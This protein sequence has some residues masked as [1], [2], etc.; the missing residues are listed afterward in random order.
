MVP[1]ES[2][3]HF[4]LRRNVDRQEQFAA[5]GNPDRTKGRDTM[6]MRY[7]ACPLAAVI[8][9]AAAGPSR[10]DL[11]KAQDDRA[12]VAGTTTSVLVDVLANDGELG[13]GLRILK[14]FKPAHGSVSVE[15]GRVRYTPTRGFTGSDSFRYMAQAEKSQPGQATVNV[16]VGPGGVA[17]QLR[18]QV[19][20][21]PIPG[22]VVT[23]S[24]GGFDFKTVA[25]ANGNYVLDIAALQGDAFVTLTA[26]GESSSGVPITFYSLVGEIVRLNAASGSDG[27]LTRDEFNQLNVTN[28]STAQYSLL[29]SAN[30]GTPPDSDQELLPL[31]QNIDLDKMLELA[32]IIKLVV[33]GGVA[34]PAGSTDLLDLIS[35]PAAVADFKADLAPGQ[36]D[37]AIDAVS[38]DPNLVPD[39]RP[40]AIP[41]SYTLISASAPGT[42]RVGA[43]GLGVV[44]AFNNTGASSG[45]GN[46]ICDLSCGDFAWSL[47]G[48]DIK[49]TVA[50]P[51]TYHYQVP[52][53]GAGCTSVVY[54]VSDALTG[55][56]LHRLQ[57]G[58]GVDFVETSFTYQI[59]YTDPNPGDTCLPPADGPVTQATR[60]L[61]FEA[62]A[63]ELPFA[64]GESFGRMA[65]NFFAPGS[66]RRG[67]AIFDFD[68]HQV[69]IP[70]FLPTFTHSVVNGRLQIGLTDATTGQVANYEYR[71]YQMDGSR[72]EGM[73]MI[74]TLPD[75]TQR[76]EYNLSSRVQPGYAFD[77][78]TMPG[79]WRSGFDASQFQG[80]P[81]IYPGFYVELNNDAGRSGNQHSVE[82]GG[83]LSYSGNFSWNVGT[84]GM[85]AS[86]WKQPGVPGTLA[87]CPA[88]STTCF[89]IR[90]RTWQP[91][92]REGNR[93]YVL[94][95]IM[96]HTA[97]NQPWVPNPTGQRTNFYI[98]Q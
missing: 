20:D 23:V 67:A 48:G 68:T 82:A 58:A 36:L 75:G 17:M 44:L 92:G 88:D 31:A 47:V 51:Y 52:G 11:Q 45:T 22:A 69:A 16:E 9:L 77:L 56:G 86:Y 54:D 46:S 70:E 25:D 83:V 89:E 63:G 57:D 79:N 42:I 19:T 50:A 4:V 5:P 96:I 14:V 85:V 73:L 3:G 97:P 74:A 27:V 7:L 12:I 62:G 98:L 34:L 78:A 6:R 18:G 43:G 61:A 24:V 95:D 13:P 1:P 72:G 37:L 60:Y 53:T 39:F 10:A 49:G 55:F 71:R 65:I 84:G 29:T 28:L 30:G 33:D 41:A 38:E 64:T 15:N 40:G 93:I 66:L 2:S 59:A 35:D 94:E 8:A 90:R 26:T 80:N 76:S 91:L 32:A 21:S 81:T 87:A